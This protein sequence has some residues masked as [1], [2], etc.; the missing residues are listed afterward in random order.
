MEDMDTQ[1]PLITVYV[2]AYNHEKYVLQ[3]LESIGQQTLKNFEWIVVDDCSKDSTPDILKREQG[4]FGYKLILH[5]K[6]KGLSATLNEILELTTTKYITGCAS[7]DYWLPNKLE[8]QLDFMEQHPEYAVSFGKSIDV[9]VEGNVLGEHINTSYR[10]GFIF[11]DIITMKFHPPVNQMFQ[12]R[13]LKDI[14]GY[15]S[16]IVAEDFYMNCLLSSKYQ[17]GYIPEVLSYYRVAPNESKRDP[18]SLYKSHEETILQYKESELFKKAYQL[19]CKRTFLGIAPFTKYKLLALKY[20]FKV[21]WANVD[22]AFGKKC[23]SY[24]FRWWKSC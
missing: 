7:D 17:I 2:P 6:N 1:K 23:I 18:Y 8:L 11:S 24:L 5:E 20:L 16:G 4:R 21:G 13:I 12:T 14:G 19:Q 10:S 22:L 15:P 9:D 3:C